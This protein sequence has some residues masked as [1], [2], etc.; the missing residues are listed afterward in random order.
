MSG[1]ELSKEDLDQEAGII[2]TDPDQTWDDEPADDDDPTGD[3][4]ADPDDVAAVAV[5]EED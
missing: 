1:V 5:I 3:L 2:P 4:L